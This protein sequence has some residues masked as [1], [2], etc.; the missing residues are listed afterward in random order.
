MRKTVA[1]SREE[2][3]SEEVTGVTIMKR[4]KKQE[5]EGRRRDRPKEESRG[6][7]ESVD[8]KEDQQEAG[9][10]SSRKVEVKR[11]KAPKA[12]REPQNTPASASVKTKK[13]AKSTRAK[14]APRSECKAGSQSRDEKESADARNE[15]ASP[16][17]VEPSREQTTS[18]RVRRERERLAPTPTQRVRPDAATTR[19]GEHRNTSQRNGGDAGGDAST[20]KGR[21]RSRAEPEYRTPRRNTEQRKRGRA[22]SR[23]RIRTQNEGSDELRQPRKPGRRKVR[24]SRNEEAEQGRRP[25]AKTRARGTVKREAARS[26][27]REPGQTAVKPVRRN[28]GPASGD[29][30]K[31]QKKTTSASEEGTNQR[32]A[33]GGAQRG[34]GGMRIN[35][36]GGRETRADDGK[37]REERR[38]SDRSKKGSASRGS[39]ER[40]AARGRMLAELTRRGR[41]LGVVSRRP[42]T[43]CGC[44]GLVRY[45]AFGPGGDEAKEKWRQRWRRT[46]GRAGGESPQWRLSEP[47]AGRERA[48]GHPGG[49]NVA[50][51]HEGERHRR[52]SEAAQTRRDG[53]RRKDSTRGGETPNGREL[54]R[55]G[56]NKERRRRPKFVGRSGDAARSVREAP[57]TAQDRVSGAEQAEGRESDSTSTKHEAGDVPPTGRK[58]GEKK[59][60]RS[61]TLSAPPS[62]AVREPSRHARERDDRVKVDP[63]HN[64]PPV[65]SSGQEKVRGHNAGGSQEPGPRR[66]TAR[67]GRKIEERA[68][69][70]TRKAA[71]RKGQ[72]AARP[73][74]ES[75]SL[76]SATRGARDNRAR[77]GARHPRMEIRLAGVRE[78]KWDKGRQVA[79]S[80][81]PER[82]ARKDKEAERAGA[83]SRT[84]KEPQTSKRERA[85]RGET[86]M[87]KPEGS[88]SRVV[89]GTQRK[90]SGRAARKRRWE[91]AR[92]GVSESQ[93]PRRRGRS[94]SPRSRLGSTVGRGEHEGEE[95]GAVG[96][97]QRTRKA[98]DESGANGEIGSPVPAQPEDLDRQSGAAAH[99][100]K[101]RP[102]STPDRG[103]GRRRRFKAE[104]D[105]QAGPRPGPKS[106]AT[107]RQITGGVEERPR[108]GA[109]KESAKQRGERRGRPEAEKRPRV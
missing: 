74:S 65:G 84:T 105:K 86:L 51:G 45:D 92:D 20:R 79:E 2:R 13:A 34:R 82:K 1:T 100:R 32:T 88:T 73:E 77:G 22:E 89:E 24:R 8:G 101:Q 12:R 29:R 72:R 37:E 96:R 75:D 103:G 4:S 15:R 58:R 14:T 17:G 71:L 59:R 81:G 97:R 60:P 54:R 93:C 48:E 44:A 69:E 23:K 56:D 85:S 30:R 90:T 19:A 27:R 87:Y 98:Q 26:D 68:V 53:H 11:G 76:R 42:A 50:G 64:V 106:R 39:E 109:R 35:R 107:R 91:R 62:D 102:R 61:T 66:G 43:R 67:E 95:V 9:T 94:E 36:R 108:G 33:A 5:C 78:P 6:M 41:A 46:T 38:G 55:A 83:G 49:R 47:R 70:Y 57:P 3:Q 80:A 25:D 7:I 21:E 16:K 63:P 104:R 31:P 18:A 28:A 10:D 52:K 40:A 99:E